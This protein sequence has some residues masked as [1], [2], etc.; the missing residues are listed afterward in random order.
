MKVFGREDC[1]GVVQSLDGVVAGQRLAGVD[2]GQ[3]DPSLVVTTGLG[4]V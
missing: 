4:V 3:K 1:V 2:E